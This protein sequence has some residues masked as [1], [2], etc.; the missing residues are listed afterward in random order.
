VVDARTRVD[1]AMG[2][3]ERVATMLEDIKHGHHAAVGGHVTN[4][5]LAV[6]HGR[7]HPAQRGH[8]G[9]TG[10][11]IQIAGRTQV[12][13]V[14]NSIRVFRLFTGDKTLAED[15]AVAM[16]TA[17]KAVDGQLRLTRLTLTR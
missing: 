14:H 11:G 13:T 3:V 2:A 6:R 15:D 10:R 8:G 7:H 17:A 5:G 1:E 16:R 12:D 9:R 4:C